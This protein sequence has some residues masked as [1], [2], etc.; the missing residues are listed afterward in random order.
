MAKTIPKGNKK[1]KAKKRP[2]D[3]QLERPKRKEITSFPCGRKL[4]HP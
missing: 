2:K 3:A 1:G 4:F